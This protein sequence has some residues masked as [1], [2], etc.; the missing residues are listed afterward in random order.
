MEQAFFMSVFLQRQVFRRDDIRPLQPAGGEL[1]AAVSDH[2]EKCV[3][4]FDDAVELARYDAGDV[5]SG[6]LP[7]R[8]LSVALR[9]SGD[10]C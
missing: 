4:G 9:R 10:A 8:R 6:K 2:I 5:D 1:F 3:V 7:G